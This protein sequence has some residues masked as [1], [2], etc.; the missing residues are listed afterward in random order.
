MLGIEI[1]CL[2][3]GYVQ[4]IDYMGCDTD[5]VQAARV[6]YGPSNRKVHDD[7]GLLRYLVRHWHTSPLEMCEVKFRCKMPIFVARQWIRHRTACLSADTLLHFDLPGGIQRRGNQLFTLTV[8]EVWARFQPTHNVTR[9]DKQRDPY[10]RRS[11]VQKMLLRSVGEETGQVRHT[12]I[13][14]IWESGEKIV[15]EVKTSAGHTATM[16]A[17]HLCLTSEGWLKLKDIV[18]LTAIE[19]GLRG[20]QGDPPKMMVVGPG[21]T[22]GAS[23]PNEVDPTT[24]LWLPVDG[25]EDLYE[26]SNQGRVRRIAGGRGTSNG[27]LPKPPTISNSHAVVSLSCDGVSRTFQVHQLMMRTF[28]KEG[29]FPGAQ[30]RH[31]DG[32]GLNNRLDNL[33]WGSAQENATDRVLH[34]A[35]TALTASFDE[36]ESVKCVGVRPTYDLEVEGPWHNF[37]AGGLIVHNSVNEMSLR[38]TEAPDEFY[39]PSLEAVAL[40]ATD[41]KQ[42][43]SETVAE[44]V[45]EE[46]LRLLKAEQEDAFAVY[47]RLA[48]QLGIARE[49]ARTVLPVSLYT[50]WIWKIDLHNLFHFLRL[51]LDSHAQYEIRVFAEAMASFVRAWV[52]L[53][54]EAFEDYRL[55]AMNLS[56]ME[57]EAVGA[58]LRGEEIPEAL[59][60]GR[61]L[62][63][64]QAKLKILRG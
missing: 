30:I 62:K 50:Q 8:G 9:P 61:E 63:E 51:R 58:L 38:Y 48:G 49:L 14:D 46:V 18:D 4:P 37:S 41:N 11:R 19:E 5:I 16:S 3:L 1:P 43:R 10:F 60:T 26:V 52:P 31:L 57:V 40:Q 2:D 55:R 17:D 7:R 24:E 64:F 45:G 20:F 32:N 21:R 23:F 29:Y 33:E 12:R 15:Y 54:W 35:T 22:A 59:L 47:E 6:S 56:R 42:G 27:V 34:G 44:N 53:A 25:W 36:I 39:L 28:K 13:V